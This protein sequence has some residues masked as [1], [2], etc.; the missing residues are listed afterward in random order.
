MSPVCFFRGGGLN[1]SIKIHKIMLS[2]VYEKI[3]YTKV[4]NK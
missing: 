2:L 4:G 1:T 3:N